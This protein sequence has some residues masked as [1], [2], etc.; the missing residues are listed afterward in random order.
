MA[1]AKTSRFFDHWWGRS[2]RISAGRPDAPNLSGTR[3]AGSASDFSRSLQTKGDNLGCDSNERAPTAQRTCANQIQRPLGSQGRIRT[4]RVAGYHSVHDHSV[5]RRRWKIRKAIRPEEHAVF[6][7]EKMG[8]ATLFRSDRILVG[9]NSFEPGQEHSAPRPL[10]HGQGVSRA[11]G[12]WVTSYSRVA[13]FPWRRARCW[14]RPKG[15]AHGIRNDAEERL[16]VLAI[17]APAP[18]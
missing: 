18:G 17:L 9:L 13:R 1:A 10:G 3:F 14:S 8:K 7:A 6:A 5:W 4:A 2:N 15:V 11:L 16:I 12:A